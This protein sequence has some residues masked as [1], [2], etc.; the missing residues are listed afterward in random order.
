MALTNIHSD[1]LPITSSGLY[2]LYHNVWILVK[3]QYVGRLE[4][5]ILA[6]SCQ[7]YDHL[8]TTTKKSAIVI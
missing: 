8:A 6:L 4:P 5:M 1:Q 2:T 3:D 7:Y